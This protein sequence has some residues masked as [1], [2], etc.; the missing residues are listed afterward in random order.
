MTFSA[1]EPNGI[2]CSN[3][4]T[5]SSVIER[6][7]PSGEMLSTPIRIVLILA[8]MCER[9]SHQP[10]M[11]M[12]VCGWVRLVCMKEVDDI[13]INLIFAR[14]RSERSQSQSA[15]ESGV[16]RVVDPADNRERK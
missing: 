12:C 8:E 11:L 6:K 14:R 7:L 16:C 13:L 10:Q 15:T 2:L 1:A 4:N 5:M 9:I 3:Y